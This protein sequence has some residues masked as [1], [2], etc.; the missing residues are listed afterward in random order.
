MAGTLEGIRVIDCGVMQLGPTAA[1][2]LGDL[3]ADVIK[4]EPPVTGEMGRGIE[5]LT[6]A[7]SRINAKGSHFEIWNR[8]KRSVTL[9]LNKEPGRQVF[10]RL[11]AASDVVLNN[12]RNGVAEYKRLKARDLVSEVYVQEWMATYKPAV[13]PPSRAALP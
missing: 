10:Y 11:V 5:A 12:W 4:V 13:L 3:G 6:S 2:L 8:N 1:T 7:A 9:D